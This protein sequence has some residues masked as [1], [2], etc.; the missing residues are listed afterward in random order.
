MKKI[1]P[2]SVAHLAT[3]LFICKPTKN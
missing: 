2:G 1:T 3:R